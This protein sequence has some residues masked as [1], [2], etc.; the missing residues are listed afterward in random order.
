MTGP[1]P[2]RLL[3]LSFHTSAQPLPETLLT[4]DFLTS[5]TDS[6]LSGWKLCVTASQES[7]LRLNKWAS[8]ASD[9]ESWVD[10]YKQWE[11]LSTLVFLISKW[12][13]YAGFSW[14]LYRV[15][16]VSCPAVPGAKPV[17]TVGSLILLLAMWW[18][19]HYFPLGTL[20]S[21]GFCDALFPTIHFKLQWHLVQST[22]LPISFSCIP[23]AERSS[24]PHQ[25][26]L[27][28]GNR[29]GVNVS[30]RNHPSL[31]TV[32]GQNTLKTSKHGTLLIQT[33]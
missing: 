9:P 15:L 23:L 33:F 19:N 30:D 31:Q 13:Q 8:E 28:Y 16:Y 21:C 2:D 6:F 27:A 24:N 12:G 18:C 26:S 14:G 4:N 1:F 32:P 5:N 17:L 7:T 29:I 20:L 10:S 25:F 11:H 3:S 22:K